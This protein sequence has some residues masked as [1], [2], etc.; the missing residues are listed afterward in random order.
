MGMM[1]E[2]LASAH[3][4]KKIRIAADIVSESVASV[5]KEGKIRTR[6]LCVGEWSDIKPSSTEDVTTAIIDRIKEIKSGK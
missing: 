3:N 4:D 5:L 6:D 1:L 2:W